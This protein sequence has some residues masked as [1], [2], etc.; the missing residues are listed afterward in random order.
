MLELMR[1]RL[2][3]EPDRE[4][5]LVDQENLALDRKTESS[6]R[7]LELELQREMHSE[8]INMKAKKMESNKRIARLQIESKERIVDKLSEQTVRHHHEREENNKNRNLMIYNVHIDNW[9]KKCTVQCFGTFSRWGMSSEYIV[10]AA[11]FNRDM[12]VTGSDMEK[13]STPS[14]RGPTQ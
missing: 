12:R 9:T 10:Q 4:R 5:L 2:D 8:T 6:A 7:M 1:L 14:P 11:E 3:H 13:F